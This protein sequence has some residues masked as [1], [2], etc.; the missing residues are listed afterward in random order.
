[1]QS[2][3]SEDYPFVEEFV[4]DSSG[5]VCKVVLQLADYRRLI[6]ALEDEGLYRAMQEVRH[7]VPLSWEAALQV[8][9][10]NES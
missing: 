4:T 1:M 9:D 8:L 2:T 5:Q 7:E 3:Q 10:S 6:E